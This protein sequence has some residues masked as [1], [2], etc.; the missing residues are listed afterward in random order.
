MTVSGR[1]CSYA[2]LS[3]CSFSR[4]RFGPSQWRFHRRPTRS[5]RY[6]APSILASPSINPLPLNP[7]D[8]L[9][10]LRPPDDDKDATKAS[11]HHPQAPAEG[12]AAWLTRTVSSIRKS[13]PRRSGAKPAGKDRK[14]WRRSQTLFVTAL[15]QESHGGE[16]TSGPS[17]SS[18]SSSL[19]GCPVIPIG[20]YLSRSRKAIHN[21]LQQWILLAEQ[22]MGACL[23]LQELQ[24]DIMQLQ[25][26]VP[27]LGLLDAL[28]QPLLEGNY[29]SPEP[30][31]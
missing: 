18:P 28:P 2:S 5:R 19:A 8:A 21:T 7:H 1:A 25:C 29:S 20:P 13:L 30:A 27:L 16:M 17:V 22:W 24:L 9:Q 6:S 10:A 3:S 26:E 15:T 23:M 4:W 31:Q 12:A 11:R 14:A